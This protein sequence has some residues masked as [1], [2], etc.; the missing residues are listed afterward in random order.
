[1]MSFMQPRRLD[2]WSLEPL[3][4]LKP[5]LNSL[6]ERA[7]WMF[8]SAW[9]VQA[10]ESFSGIVACQFW[11]SDDRFKRAFLVNRMGNVASAVRSRKELEP[12]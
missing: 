7:R 11:R 8:S 9:M 10:D 1:M 5:M 3:K 4:P 6:Y 2:D 12:V